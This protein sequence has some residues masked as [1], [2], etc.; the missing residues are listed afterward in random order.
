MEL[1]DYIAI[2]RKRWI[3][4]LTLSVLALAAAVTASLLATP[5]Y[6]ATTQVFVSVQGGTTTSDLLQGSNFTQQQVV[7][8]T[9]LV[10]SPLVLAPV[11]DNLGLAERTETLG[12][13][14]SADS[15]LNTS[16]INIT[17][18]NPNAAL[19]AATANSIATQFTQVIADL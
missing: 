14:V 16:L 6:E 18:S 13:Q 17:V 12:A 8:Y 4:V 7:S 3:S 1:Q 10:T 15:P 5:Q 2:L 11:I 9:K 19:A